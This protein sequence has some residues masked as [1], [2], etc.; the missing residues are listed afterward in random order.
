MEHAGV[1]ENEIRRVVAQRGYFPE[2]TPIRNY[3]N[4]FISGVLVA[5]WEQVFTMIKQNRENDDMPF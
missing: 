5:A 4:D 1:T 3:P 2:N